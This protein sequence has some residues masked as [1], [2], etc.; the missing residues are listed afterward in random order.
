M[1]T[2]LKLLTKR[3]NGAYRR[4]LDFL[5]LKRR[6]PKLTASEAA[7]SSG[8]TLRT[9]RRYAPSLLTVRSGRLD[10]APS[11]RLP[12]RMRMLTPRGEI[13]IL[14]RGSRTASQIG[15]YN[16][17]LREYLSTGDVKSLQSFAGKAVRSGG[18]RYEFV[19]DP[20]TINRLARPGALHFLDVYDVEGAP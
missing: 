18:R 15:R 16:N 13:T 2:A 19:T 14:T 12:R 10:V 5:S 7:K 20:A 8:T 1:S 9:V 3:D 6:N 4:V 11:D 17:A